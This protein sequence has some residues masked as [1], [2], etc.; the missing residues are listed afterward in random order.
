M[1]HSPGEL[2]TEI[3]FQ[4]VEE[5]V[6]FTDKN[7]EGKVDY[8]FARMIAPRP[9]TCLNLPPLATPLVSSTAAATDG[10]AATNT[11]H[12]HTNHSSSSKQHGNI[13]PQTSKQ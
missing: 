3:A 5:F 12:T 6:E 4:E 2:S 1:Q 10:N 13:A 9:L 8:E 11:P 7:G